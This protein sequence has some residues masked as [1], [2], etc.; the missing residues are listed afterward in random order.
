VYTRRAACAAVLMP[1]A[2]LRI[3]RRRPSVFRGH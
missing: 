1:G 3:G 2:A